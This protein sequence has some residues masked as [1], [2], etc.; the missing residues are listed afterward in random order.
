MRVLLPRETSMYGSRRTRCIAREKW[1][2]GRRAS[3]VGA[4][5]VSVPFSERE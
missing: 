3:V 2:D 4:V 1:M 5:G